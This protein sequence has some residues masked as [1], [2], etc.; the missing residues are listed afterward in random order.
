MRPRIL[1]LDDEESIRQL[2]SVYF[3]EK[4]FE[5]AAVSTAKEAMESADRGRFDV[6]IFDVNLAGENGLELL[7]Y[8]KTNF[9]NLP[10]IILTGL[11]DVDDL[12]DQAMFREANGFMRKTEPL[13]N[14]F[15][16]VK[17]YVRLSA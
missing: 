1:V 5:V 11:P 17:S 13:D 12:R 2:L 9:P 8:F 15:E 7:R 4:G 14:L 16:V 10:V 3:E 6:A